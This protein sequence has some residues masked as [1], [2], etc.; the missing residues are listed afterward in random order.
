MAVIPAA[1]LT[2]IAARRSAAIR[3]T[4][5]RIASSVDLSGACST[6]GIGTCFTDIVAIIVEMIVR[7]Q[8]V[9][10]SITATADR[11]EICCDGAVVGSIEIATTNAVN[12]TPA[13]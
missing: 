11:C 13:T 1:S 3:T 10:A 2:E 5:I 4:A 9:T 6:R 7:G 8:F 12:A